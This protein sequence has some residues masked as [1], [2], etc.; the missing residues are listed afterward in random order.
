MVDSIECFFEVDIYCYGFFLF[1]IC[2]SIRG[3][4]KIQVMAIATVREGLQT[5]PT[6]PLPTLSQGWCILGASCDQGPK[7]MPFI[8]CS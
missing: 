4:V 2:I 8:N 6:E 7:Q 3:D 5:A 1:I